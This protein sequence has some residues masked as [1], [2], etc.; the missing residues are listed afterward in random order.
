MCVACIEFI[1]ETLTFKEFQSALWEVSR[2][3][4][5]HLKEIDRVLLGGAKDLT[6]IRDQL[7]E[8]DSNRRK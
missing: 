4:L 7:G 2:E 5:E 8:L 1:K 6:K 3:D